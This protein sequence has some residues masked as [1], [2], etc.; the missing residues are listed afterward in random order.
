[1]PK[2]KTVAKDLISRIEMGEFNLTNKL[3]IEDELINDYQ[4]S[5]NTIRSAIKEL[6]KEGKVYSR[7]GS[8]YFIRRRLKKNSISIAGTNGLTHDF[9]NSKFE[10]Q[11]LSV[12]LIYAD[13]E[14]S[15]NMLC[16][17]GTP[18][19]FIKRLRIIDDKKFALEYTYYNKNIVPYL[20]RE[21]AE[22]SIYNYLQNDLKLRFGFADKDIYAIKLTNEQAEL[23][24]VNE[25]DPGLVISDTVY[26]E[27]GQLF[28]TSKMIYNYKYANFYVTAIR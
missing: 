14:L 21:I 12:E 16:E 23:L 11:V 5:R 3:P 26:L 19:Y 2:Y 1:M 13:Q 17:I 7:Q 15:E 28:N 25:G 22:K 10:T 18:V 8:G 4:V 20:G 9:P 6:M 27:N 24:E